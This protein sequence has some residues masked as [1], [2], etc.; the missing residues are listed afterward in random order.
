MLILFLVI[1]ELKGKQITSDKC[2]SLLCQHVCLRRRICLYL[3]VFQFST[4]KGMCRKQIQGADNSSE[5]L[6]FGN[7]YVLKRTGFCPETL[8]SSLMLFGSLASSAEEWFFHHSEKVLT[9]WPVSHS[10]ELRR[11]GYFPKNNTF[12][13]FTGNL[14]N[15]AE[16]LKTTSMFLWVRGCP[17]VALPRSQRQAHLRLEPGG[18]SLDG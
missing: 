14:R 11:N 2:S 7:K 6:R 3:G 15:R 13:V 17:L 18:R 12:L 9:C 5:E 4:F 8:N 16:T 1:G 10:L